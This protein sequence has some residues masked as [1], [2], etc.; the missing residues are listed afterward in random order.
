MTFGGESVIK[1]LVNVQFKEKI[2]L[3]K[4]SQNAEIRDMKTSFPVSSITVK[5]DPFTERNNK[6]LKHNN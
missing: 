6:C 4:S 3:I 2:F 5:C 1:M